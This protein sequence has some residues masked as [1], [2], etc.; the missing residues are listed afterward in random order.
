M[1]SWQLLALNAVS[2]CVVKPFVRRSS[3]KTIPGHEAETIE[4]MRRWV[5]RLDR[6]MTRNKPISISAKPVEG[7]PSYL[8]VNNY[9]GV[10]RTILYLHGGGMIIHLPGLYKRWAQRL[11]VAA[12]ARVLLVDYRLAPE[13][14]YPA[15]GDDC[16][17]AYQ[18][19]VVE[20]A[21]D[22]A[23]IV[24]AGDSAGGYL[25]LAILLRIGRSKLGNPSCAIALSPL[26]DFSLGSLSMF[27]NEGADP[28]LSNHLIP[29]VRQLVLG[30]HLCTEPD[31]SPV[32]ADLGGFPPLQVHVS[33]HEI[34]RDDG[35]RIVNRAR[36]QGATAELCEW[37]KT[38][39]VHPL[40]EWLPES[41]DALTQM[42]K[43]MDRHQKPND[44]RPLNW[45]S[46]I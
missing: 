12:N 10:Q 4:K 19:L 11:A 28:L 22:P 27:T 8:W 29:V 46:P 6:G 18:W 36:S 17:A 34:L 24:I 15:S 3:A 42:L 41:N 40:F 14:P 38:T 30:D 20:N 13:H 23:S 44:P 7:K 21:I 31:V 1:R 33:S 35:V 37:Y 16:F 2:R 9:P 32:Y 26:S 25:T 5:A 39:H 43:F 45:P